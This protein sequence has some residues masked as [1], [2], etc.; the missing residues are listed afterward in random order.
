MC[1]YRILSEAGASAQHPPGGGV[2][3][4]IYGFGFRVSS[5]G[6]QVSGC[7]FIGGL[8]KRG[9]L[10]STAE[11]VGCITSVPFFLR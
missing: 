11:A 4:E 2:G 3:H 6:F 9:G 5:F 10:S 7:G 8:R 1:E